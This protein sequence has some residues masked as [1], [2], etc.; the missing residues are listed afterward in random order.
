MLIC[1]DESSKDECT[2][3]CQWGYAWLGKRCPVRSR[4]VRGTRY[5]I[6]PVLGVDGYLAYEVFEGLVTGDRFVEFVISMHT[7]EAPAH[8]YILPTTSV[9][10][11]L[12]NNYV[13]TLI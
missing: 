5:S 10:V 8:V 1:I 7:C 9:D 2:V 4:F 13:A 11:V 3:A 12:C 6:L